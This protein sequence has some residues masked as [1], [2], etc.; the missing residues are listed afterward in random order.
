M[1][2]NGCPQAT[3]LIRKLVKRQVITARALTQPHP[4]SDQ[5]FTNLEDGTL[6]R[7]DFVFLMK[8]REAEIARGER[9]SR[10]GR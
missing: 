5:C 7:R 9:R 8:A 6:S 3:G 1:Q 2:I 10:R 4:L